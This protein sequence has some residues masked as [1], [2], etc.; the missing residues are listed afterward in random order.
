MLAALF[1]SAVRAHDFSQSESAIEIDGAIVRVRIG[2]NLLEMPGVDANGDQRVSYDELDE[3]IERVFAAIKEHLTLRAPETAGTDR[4]GRVTRSST[5]TSCGW[6]SWKRSGRASV[7]SRS[8]RA[9]TGSSAEPTSISSRRGRAASSIA[10][11]SMPRARRRLSRTLASRPDDCSMVVI[12]ALACSRSVCTGSGSDR[13]GGE[14]RMSPVGSAFSGFEPAGSQLPAESC[15]GS[16]I[17]GAPAAM[18]SREARHHVDAPGVGPRR[19]WKKVKR[20]LKKLSDGLSS[21][22]QLINLALAVAELREESR[23]CAR[24][25]VADDASA[26]RHLPDSLIGLPSTLNPASSGSSNAEQHLPRLDLRI[27]QRLRDRSNPAARHRRLFS[28]S[29]SASTVKRRERALEL[30]LQLR[31]VAHAIGVGAESRIVRRGARRPTASHS[32]FH[33][34]GFAAAIISMPSLARSVS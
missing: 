16:A 5:I 8:R 34:R 21:M 3:S 1:A 20:C 31:S 12:A 28:R 9:S 6:T 14:H 18:P 17:G 24:P 22:D 26:A 10:L 25:V 32:C 11:S 23:A 33:R 30:G 29:T 2:V 15:V 27:L 13:E 4:G 19:L 7:A